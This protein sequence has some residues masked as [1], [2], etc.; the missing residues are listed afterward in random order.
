[1][2]E[3]SLEYLIPSPLQEVHHPILHRKQ[4]KLFV[5][6]DDLIHPLLSGNKYR[7]YKYNLQHFK[8]SN[9]KT[10]V[11]YG[12]AFSNH[13]H[14]TAAVCASHE[15]SCVGIVRGEDFDPE[16]PTL[17]FCKKNGMKLHFVD[18]ETYRK[19]TMS[20]E[21]NQIIS[22]YPSPFVLAEG[23]SNRL[24]LQGVGEICAEISEQMNVFPDFI[25][26][27]VGSGATAAGI[28]SS[29][30]SSTKLLAFCVLKNP[31]LEDV[32]EKMSGVGQN[33]NF[34]FI[35]DYTFGGYAKTTPGLMSFI[36]DFELI[37]NIEIDPVYNAKALYGFFDLVQKDY[38]K[39]E[40]TVIWVHTGG[41]QGKVAM[42]YMH[43]KKLFKK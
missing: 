8:D 6:R 17:L 21:I 12:G 3:P 36:D 15:I 38:F 19:K 35:P 24:A 2:R 26:C 27:P 7:K 22:N 43:H 11:T 16:N 33:D 41:L 23:G 42:E 18:R 40:Q 29:I 28:L 4:I 13:L 14:A 5:K 39:T 20:D 31:K 30:P 9:F 10:L 37:C 25:F 32:I 34:I 1:M